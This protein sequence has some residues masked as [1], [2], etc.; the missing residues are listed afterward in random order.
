MPAAIHNTKLKRG[1]IFSY[2]GFNMCQNPNNRSGKVRAAGL[3]RHV[4]MSIKVHNAGGVPNRAGSRKTTS[5][6]IC[7]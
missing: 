3:L 4:A 5:E 1:W 2:S 6:I 7:T